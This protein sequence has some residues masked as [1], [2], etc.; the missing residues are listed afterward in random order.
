[1]GSQRALVAGER[2][3]LLD[4][5]PAEG[6]G[7]GLHS[8]IGEDNAV[9]FAGNQGNFELNAMRPNIIDNFLLSAG[10]LGDAC[11]KLPGF[12]VESARLNRK[13]IDEMVEAG[14]GAQP[15]DLLRQGIRDRPLGE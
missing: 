2:A 3:G 7:D 11:E 15:G 4:A 14:D 12:S 8:G 6:D 10:I 1:L 5:N 13:R 9:A